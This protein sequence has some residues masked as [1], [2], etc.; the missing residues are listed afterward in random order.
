[1]VEYTHQD[2]RPEIVPLRLVD[3]ECLRKRL[4]PIATWPYRA[5]TILVVLPVIGWWLL[6]LGFGGRLV[7]RLSLVLGAVAMGWR[8]VRYL[9]LRAGIVVVAVCGSTMRGHDVGIATAT[10]TGFAIATIG[11]VVVLLVVK[12]GWA[13][14]RYSYLQ[15]SRVSNG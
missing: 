11:D 4:F 15:C 7:L 1:M 3:L 14:R 2:A 5:C 13:K 12:S 8:W 6:E 9:W 10:A